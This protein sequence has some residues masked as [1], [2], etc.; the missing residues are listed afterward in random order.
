[1]EEK[2]RIVRKFNQ[3]NRYRDGG[4]LNNAIDDIL[5][6]LERLQKENEY[7]KTHIIY[8]EIIKLNFIPK[9]A[10]RDKIKEIQ[11]DFKERTQYNDIFYFNY[12]NE[13]AHI[14]E[15]LKKL[16]GE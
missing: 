16:L 1:M 3:E 11:N 2:I 9:Q 14:E 4:V 12:S 5:N 6:E 10:I 15:V 8:P 7:L 13:Y